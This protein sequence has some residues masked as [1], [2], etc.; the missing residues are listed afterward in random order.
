MPFQL[1][2]FISGVLLTNMHFASQCCEVLNKHKSKRRRQLPCS[3]NTRV[4]VVSTCLGPA[5]KRNLYYSCG[6]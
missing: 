3:V 4:D 5:A 1:F 6:A 2:H